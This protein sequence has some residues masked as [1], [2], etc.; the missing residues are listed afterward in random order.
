ME[1]KTEKIAEKKLEKQPFDYKKSHLISKDKRTIQLIDPDRYYLFDVKE[2]KTTKTGPAIKFK[3]DETA[4][5][6]E[7]II[8]GDFTND[9]KYIFYI[10]DQN[11]LYRVNTDTGDIDHILED[12][13]PKDVITSGDN[14]TA[15]ILCN[16]FI[17]VFDIETSEIIDSV[18]FNGHEGYCISFVP[19][20]NFLVCHGDDKH[21]R[22]YNTKDKKLEYI[23]TDTYTS[24]D[25]I[26]Y[27]ADASQM[28]FVTDDEMIVFDID[29]LGNLFSVNYGEFYL[30]EQKTIIALDDHHVYKMKAKDLDDLKADFYE[31]FGDAKLTEEQRLMFKID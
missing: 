30:H 25:A 7:R 1:K 18:E 6:F 11:H 12:Y 20:S 31:Q 22:I 17:A 3:I 5:K 21:L 9:G 4:E 27:I 29:T 2:R 23:S 19:D 8:A 26:N 13:L 10:S 16:G 15:A 24:I 14:A 28:V